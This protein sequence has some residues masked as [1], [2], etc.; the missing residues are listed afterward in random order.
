MSLVNS[1]WPRVEADRIVILPLGSTEQ[2]GPHLPLDTDTVIATYVAAHV[3]EALGVGA[4][5]APAIPYGS[6]G[7]HQA[8]AGTISIGTEALEHLLVEWVRSVSTWSQRLLIVNGHGG[9]IN[10]VKGAERR[11]VSEGRTVMVC[12]CAAPGMDAHAGIAETSM[13][14]AIDPDRVRMDDAVV[15]NTSRLAQLLPR[16]RTEGVRAVAPSGVLGDPTSA[17][18]DLGHRL[19]EEMIGSILDR[20]ARGWAPSG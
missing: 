20:V 11:L 6:S 4:V 1:A 16:L 2:H 12:H 9:N 8:F 3:Q 10:A 17:S 5:V 13:M 15:G 14:L 19:L 7:E 18:S